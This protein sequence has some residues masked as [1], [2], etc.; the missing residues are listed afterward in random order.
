M[1][2]SQ[3]DLAKKGNAT[4]L[5]WLGKQYLGQT[6]K[7]TAE[8]DDEVNME[9][10]SKR[11]RSMLEAV[12]LRYRASVNQS[13]NTPVTASLSCSW[14]NGHLASQLS[15]RD[16]SRVLTRSIEGRA[17]YDHPMPGSRVLQ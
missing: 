17:G 7:P 3:F 11:L 1:R 15:T 8:E 13:S 6:D 9:E 10:F 12:A 14:H 2:R 4:M 5:I 16:L